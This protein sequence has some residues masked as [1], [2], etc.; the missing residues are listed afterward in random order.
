MEMIGRILLFPISFDPWTWSR[1]GVQLQNGQKEMVLHAVAGGWSM[2]LL[3]KGY[4]RYK[5][6]TCVLV[7][8]VWARLGKCL[9]Q[10]WTDWKVCCIRLGMFPELKMIGDGENIVFPHTTMHQARLPCFY[11]SLNIWLWVLNIYYYHLSCLCVSST[12]LPL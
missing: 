12:S 1:E 9:E 7:F 4:C 10:G 8:A 6:T 3:A 2:E 5:N 11:F